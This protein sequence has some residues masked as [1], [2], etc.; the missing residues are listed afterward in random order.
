M[1]QYAHPDVLIDVQ[2]LADHLDDPNLRILEVDMSS[3]TYKNAHLPGAVFWTTKDLQLPDGSINLEAI[4]FEQLMSRS[5]IT[6]ETTVVAYGSYPG[7]GGWIFWLLNLFGHHQ[8]K[9]LNGGY[10]QWQAAG[11]PCTGG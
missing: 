6:H 1:S 11:D 4:A 9:V 3:E 8:V 7:T 2:W 5:G 10:Q